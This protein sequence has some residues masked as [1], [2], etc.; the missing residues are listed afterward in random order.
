MRFQ[1]ATGALAPVAFFAGGSGARA[2]ASEMTV[3]LKNSGPFAL[4]ELKWR[5]RRAPMIC[6][7][8]QFEI[9]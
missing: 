6:L 3:S 1:N 2:S 7:T 4:R 5:E 9:I 8:A